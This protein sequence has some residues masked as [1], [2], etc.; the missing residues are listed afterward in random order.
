[1]TD[2]ELY[3]EIVKELG[4]VAL[5]HKT[6]LE[7]VTL[8]IEKV[9]AHLGGETIIPNTP[10]PPITPKSSNPIGYDRPRD[11]KSIHDTIPNPS[12]PSIRELKDHT[13]EW[14]QMGKEVK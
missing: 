5:L 4:A 9:R 13:M 1:M 2:R 6:A 12:G 11:P 3:V 8:T 10:T 7:R 14:T